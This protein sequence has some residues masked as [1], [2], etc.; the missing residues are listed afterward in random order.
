M[1]RINEINRKAAN[2]KKLL[3]DPIFKEAL[4]QLQD[5]AI[6]DFSVATAT[7]EQIMAAHE[8]IRAA[9]TFLWVLEGWISDKAYEDKRKEGSAP[10]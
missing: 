1:D 4:K 2:A 9:Q 8:K 5:N 7:P 10:Q 6:N 3:S